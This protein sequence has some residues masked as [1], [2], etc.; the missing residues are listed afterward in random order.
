[1]WMSHGEGDARAAPGRE[2]GCSHE[3]R[4]EPWTC[5][6]CEDGT[7]NSH[8]VTNTQTKGQNGFV[9]TTEIKKATSA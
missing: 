8:I 9:Q 7:K 3:T 4:E 6:S 5:V 2:R 1:M